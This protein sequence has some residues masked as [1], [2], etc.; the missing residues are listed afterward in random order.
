MQIGT[1]VYFT[2]ADNPTE[3]SRVFM[4]NTIYQEFTERQWRESLSML[5]FGTISE[6]VHIKN[7][8][9]EDIT[10]EVAEDE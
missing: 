10:D 4:G 8:C 1:R 5:V 6:W 3:R 9:V 7:I 2:V